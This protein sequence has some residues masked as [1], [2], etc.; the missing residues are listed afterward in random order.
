MEPSGDS[1]G[2]G[3]D[4]FVQAHSNSVDPGPAA[5]YELATSLTVEALAD[6]ECVLVNDSSGDAATG[7]ST[8]ASFYVGQKFETFES[9]AAHI[10]EY[11]AEYYI[12]FWCRDSRSVETA[13]KRIDRFLSDRI[14]YYELTYRCIHGGKKFKARGKGKHVT[15]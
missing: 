13:R 3:C 4:D 10:K 6:P 15:A 1:D 9:L 12:Q 2:N 5:G 8:T 7:H 11:E 14:K